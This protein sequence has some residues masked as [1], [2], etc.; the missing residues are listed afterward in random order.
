MK[1]DSVAHIPPIASLKLSYSL[2]AKQKAK[3]WVGLLFLLTKH[4]KNDDLSNNPSIQKVT[5]RD[6][7][8]FRL[9]DVA[10]TLY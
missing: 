1:S 8:Q 7:V 2:N 3:N 6:F 5:I 9:T 10:K 4:R